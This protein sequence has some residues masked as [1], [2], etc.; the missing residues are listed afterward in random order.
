M[1]KSSEKNNQKM[2]NKSLEKLKSGTKSLQ[3]S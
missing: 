1:N 3:K 2:N